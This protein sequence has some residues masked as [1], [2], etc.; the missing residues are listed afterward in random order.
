M[1]SLY[2]DGSTAIRRERKRIRRAYGSVR[3]GME[4][5][6]IN[7]YGQESWWSDGGGKPKTGKS[8]IESPKREV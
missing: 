8:P 7:Q 2:G 5:S 4:K 1:R 3:A 6:E